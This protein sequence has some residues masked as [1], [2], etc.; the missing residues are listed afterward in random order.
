MYNRAA[1]HA[2]NTKKCVMKKLVV[3]LSAVGLLMGTT[4]CLQMPTKVERKQ[5]TSGWTN[6]AKHHPYPVPSKNRANQKH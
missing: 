1:P 6:P 3:M 5:G 2:F 4:G